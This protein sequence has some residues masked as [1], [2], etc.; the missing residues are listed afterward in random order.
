MTE[1]TEPPE[2]V[3]LTDVARTVADQFR[4]DNDSADISLVCPDEVLLS[5]HPAVLR[6]VL[7]EL[8]ENSLEHTTTDSPHVEISVR[9]E[10][11][12]AVE[13]SVADD[14]PGLP[15]RE[16]EILTAGAETQLKHG[17]GIGLW[18][19]TWAVT[20]LGGDLEFRANDPEGSVVTVRLYRTVS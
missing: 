10:S 14:G 16:Q 1:S 3:D 20:Q 19:V 4:A 18:F 5:S 15:E 12:E 13:L 9:E 6:Q 17:Q 11:D 2:S 8:V 7:S